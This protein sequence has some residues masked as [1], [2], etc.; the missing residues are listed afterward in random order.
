MYV[1][2]YVCVNARLNARTYACMYVRMDACM[3]ITF[4]CMYCVRIYI[5]HLGEHVYIQVYIKHPGEHV[6]IQ[7]LYIHYNMYVM[8]LARCIFKMSVASFGQVLCCCNH[9]G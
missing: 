9:G 3:S 7:D 8:L 1:C 2:V 4:V 6:N 5:Q